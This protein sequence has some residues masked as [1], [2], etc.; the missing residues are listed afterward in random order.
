MA[1][2]TRDDDD[3]DNEEGSSRSSISQKKRKQASKKRTSTIGSS[4][5]GWDQPGFGL[6]SI[7]KKLRV[8]NIIEF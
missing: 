4:E 3:D 6:P 8:Y 7:R 1:M 5:C 2:T